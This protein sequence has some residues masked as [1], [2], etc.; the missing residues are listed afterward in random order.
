LHISENGRSDKKR[1]RVT[2]NQEPCRLIT[3]SFTNIRIGALSHMDLAHFSCASA[4][5]AAI[6]MA[7][8]SGTTAPSA[9]RG[10]E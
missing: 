9:C 6:L 4:S 3:Y 2:V 8:P 10:G 7:A 5:S 1:E